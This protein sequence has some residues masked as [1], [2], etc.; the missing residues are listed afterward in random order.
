[1]CIIA[2][3]SKVILVLYHEPSVSYTR[4]SFEIPATSDMH[5][6]KQH[7]LNLHRKTIPFYMLFSIQWHQFGFPVL[8]SLRLYASKFMRIAIA[9]THTH[10]LWV[11]QSPKHYFGSTQLSLSIGLVSPHA[12]VFVMLFCA[13]RFA[14][15]LV[16]ITLVTVFIEYLALPAAAVA[17]SMCIS[18]GRIV[19]LWFHANDS[20]SRPDDRISKLV[21]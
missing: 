6:R 16:F 1:M 2:N 21:I 20:A 11:S 5:G 14:H 7:L 10:W 18:S 9:H 13:F 12:F 15:S 8:S 4:N 19:Y 3:L 17:A